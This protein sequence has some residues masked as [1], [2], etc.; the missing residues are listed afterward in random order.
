MNADLFNPHEIQE[1]YWKILLEEFAALG[2]EGT[3]YAR[4]HARENAV[5]TF[6][7]KSKFKLKKTET[8]HFNE[9]VDKYC[10]N[11]DLKGEGQR[12]VTF[13]LLEDI[14]TGKQLVIG[15]S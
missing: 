3:A 2:Y 11:K 1:F 12:A 8:H 14:Q 9:L 15:R 13:T 10:N 7:R 6:F 4:H 5:A